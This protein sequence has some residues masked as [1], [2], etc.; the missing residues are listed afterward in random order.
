MLIFPIQTENHA[1][2]M[3]LI[4][5]DP[6]NL[7]RM[8]A[9][10]PAEVQMAQL[11]KA[12]HLL[13]QPIIHICYEENTPE[14]RKLVQSGDIKAILRFLGRGW[15]FRPEAGDHDRGPESIHQAQ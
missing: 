13:L 5:L 3:L 10:D 15:K 14:W 1:S 4:V 11:R 7:E 12:G 8:K 2:D 6:A 9:A